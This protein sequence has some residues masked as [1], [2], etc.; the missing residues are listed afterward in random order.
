M[1]LPGWL[2]GA[3]D[4]EL[5]RAHGQFLFGILSA[6]GFKVRFLIDG[7]PGAIAE[8]LHPSGGDVEVQLGSYFLTQ[9]MDCWLWNQEAHRIPMVSRS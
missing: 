2:I 1:V 4:L 5:R 7:Q 8:V 3:I 6:S 9:S